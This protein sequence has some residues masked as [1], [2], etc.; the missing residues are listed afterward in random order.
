MARIHH[1]RIRATIPT[2][3]IADIA[4]LLIVFFLLT[5]SMTEDKGLGLTLPPA[6]SAT[7]VPRRNISNVWINSIGEIAHDEDLV[8]LEQLRSR[9]QA[10]TEGNPELII[11]IK[12]DP[13]AL[14]EW[15][16][17][18]LDEIKISGNVKI[19]IAEPD[20]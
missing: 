8:T 15:F 20:F 14:F 2:A 12:T 10:M 3:T 19:S 5:T 17:D 1:N 6:D 4:F 11:S 13:D 9:I 18:V 7:Q 16:V